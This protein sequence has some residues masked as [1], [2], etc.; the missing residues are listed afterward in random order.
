MAW[1]PQY[2]DRLN[3]LFNADDAVR[4]AS[5]TDGLSNTMA[6]GEHARTIL[7]PPISIE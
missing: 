5:V 1:T 3:G 7:T 6:F 4:T 2:D